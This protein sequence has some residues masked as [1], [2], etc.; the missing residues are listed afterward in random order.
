MGAWFSKQHR[1]GLELLVKDVGRRASFGYEL[2]DFAQAV[3]AGT[4]L[5]A[6][7]E[8]SLGELRCALAIYRSAASRQWEKVWD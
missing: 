4:P 6:G 7:P 8:Q 5:V 2:A 3:L 1:D